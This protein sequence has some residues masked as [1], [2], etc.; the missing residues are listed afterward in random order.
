M[1]AERIKVRF[2]ISF[3]SRLYKVKQILA[4]V[5]EFIERNVI[6]LP[7]DKKCELKLV[8]SELLCNAVMHGNKNDVSKNVNLSI[9]IIDGNLVKATISDEGSGFDYVRL[10]NDSSSHLNEHGRGILLAYSLVDSMFF[11][12]RGNEIIFC[13]RVGFSE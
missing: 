12:L 7:T 8:F 9:A 3:E 6:Y 13:K 1:L 10:L 2:S 5:L 4:Q 11:N